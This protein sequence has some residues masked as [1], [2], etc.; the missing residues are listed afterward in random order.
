MSLWYNKRV[1]SIPILICQT[2][3]FVFS[4][5]ADALLCFLAHHIYLLISGLLWKHWQECIGRRPHMHKLGTDDSIAVVAPVVE[6]SKL[7]L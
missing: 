1:K 3:V 6:D 4:G 7:D 2:N 5:F